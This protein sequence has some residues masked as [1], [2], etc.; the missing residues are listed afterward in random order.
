MALP[1]VGALLREGDA[2][3]IVPPFA[4]LDRP[5]LGV[6][7]LQACAAAQGVTVR[8]LYANLLLG[9]EI[10]ELPYQAVCYAASGALLGERFFAAAAYGT[11]PFGHDNGYVSYFENQSEAADDEV[12]VDLTELHRLQPQVL[13]WADA[14]AALVAERRYRVVGC[15]T[16]FE[17][18]SASVAL[19]SRIKRLSP[20]TITILG[21]ANCDGE[22]ADGVLTLSD[23]IDYVFAGECEDTFPAF[24]QQVLTGARP[25]ERIVRGLPCMSLDAVP[26]TDFTEYYE[27]LA[28]TLPESDLVKAELI[29][30]P[31]ESSR[32]CWWGHKHHCTFCGLNAQTME[33][34]EKSA[35]RVIQELQ[36]LLASHPTRKVCVVD[37]IMPRSYFRTLL[38][39]LAAEVPGIRAFYEQKSNLSLDNVVALQAAGICDIQP[40]I[41]ALSTSLLKR[42]DKGVTARQNIAL[43]RYA[44]ATGLTLT[45]NLLYAF[46]GDQA[47]D[48]EQTLALVPLLRHLEPPGGMSHLSIDRFSP[49]FGAPE[50]YGIANLRPMPGYEAVIPAGADPRL[51]GYHFIGDY[52][53]AARDHPDVIKQLKAEVDRWMALWRSDDEALPALALTPMS[54]DHYILFDSR[55]LEGAEEIQFIDRDQV[56]VALTGR[57]LDERDDVVEWALRAG[58][59]AELDGRYVPLATA[60]PAVIREFEEE[61]LDDILPARALS[62]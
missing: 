53:S 50:K 16:T 42:M 14:V 5:S 22:M 27:Q 49:Y 54:E 58:V 21:G 45:W 24:M 52:P 17:Q 30:L 15:T 18:T 59:V 13:Q 33:H 35:D 36:H 46:P 12:E 39:R 56:S 19:L 57:R 1:E 47:A 60:D 43:M 41:E 25:A 9:A 28:A 6:H 23:A 34:R 2:L 48:Y 55:G 51:I 31:Y 8:V 20:D 26:T 3:I 61:R 11:P 44:R 4:G 29:L 37:N 62:A 38:P 40:G 10:G 32:G 7:V